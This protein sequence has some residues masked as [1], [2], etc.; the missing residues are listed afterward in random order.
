MTDFQLA[1]GDYRL[2]RLRELN[3]EVHFDYKV[4]TLDKK[5]TG[6]FDKII[7]VDRNSSNIKEEDG[8]KELEKEEEEEDGKKHSRLEQKIDHKKLN[9]DKLD[10]ENFVSEKD[11]LNEFYRKSQENEDDK[12]IF[13]FKDEKNFW[14]N[15]IFR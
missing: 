13:E 3:C 7:F 14:A 6:V 9:K 8:E 1:G 15:E 10:R 11:D 5:I 12:H 2:T 4:N